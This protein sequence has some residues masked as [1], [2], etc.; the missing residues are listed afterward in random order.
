MPQVNTW[1]GLRKALEKQLQTEL[2]KV[3]EDIKAKL[4]FF[5]NKKWYQGHQE[6][7]YYNRTMDLLNSITCT[8]TEKDVNG[9]YIAIIFFDTTAMSQGLNKDFNSRMSFDGD[10]SWGGIDIC[11]LLPKWVELGNGNNEKMPW[12]NYDGVGFFADTKEWAEQNSAKLL[13]RYLRMCGYKDI[14]ITI[15]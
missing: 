14:K 4:K 9:K 1:S 10:T 11:E 13:A 8:K 6:G 2:Q 7:Q 12:L 3:G 15:H 5:L